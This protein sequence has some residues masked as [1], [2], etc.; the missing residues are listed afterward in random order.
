[1]KK[2]ALSILVGLGLLL[3]VAQ[4]SASVGFGS[5][6]GSPQGSIVKYYTTSDQVSQYVKALNSGNSAASRPGIL[7]S[8]GY[9]KPSSYQYTV[10]SQAYPA[11]LFY[12][13][14]FAPWVDGQNPEWGA[15]TSEEQIRTRLAIIAS[16]TTWV[17]TYG[18]NNGLQKVGKIAHSSAKSGRRLLA[19]Q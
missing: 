18:C 16:N 8:C 13:L 1:M 11:T 19:W 14:C 15:V 7:N 9:S 6:S 2:Y 4:S 12:G 10:I 5:L 17:R 3:V